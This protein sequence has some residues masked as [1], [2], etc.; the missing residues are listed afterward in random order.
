MTRT[1]VYSAI[2]F[3]NFRIFF[4]G[5][6]SNAYQLMNTCSVPHSV[7]KLKP[8]CSEA[9]TKFVGTHL[10][11]IHN[12]YHKVNI[13]LQIFKCNLS[14]LFLHIVFR[15]LPWMDGYHSYHCEIFGTLALG[16]GGNQLLDRQ[17]LMLDACVW[18]CG[19]L[20]KLNACIPQYKKWL[21]RRNSQ[22]FADWENCWTYTCRLHV[23]RK[24]WL[25]FLQW[26]IESGYCNKRFSYCFVPVMNNIGLRTNCLVVFWDTSRALTNRGLCSVVSISYKDELKLF[27]NFVLNVHNFKAFACDTFSFLKAIQTTNS[28]QV[29][30]HQFC[31]KKILGFLMFPD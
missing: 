30:R 11:I 5:Q 29:L 12:F 19:R 1:L 3:E 16:W 9:S 14:L 15:C 22:K 17:L 2:K 23:H 8:R 13:F 26:L 6:L 24:I 18:L 25:H 28:G 7:V 10:V 4:F 20:K 27:L 31:N 21:L